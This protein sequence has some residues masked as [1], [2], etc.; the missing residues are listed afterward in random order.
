MDLKRRFAEL[1]IWLRSSQVCGQGYGS[2]AL[3]ALTRFLH[4]AFGITEFIL[5][6]SLRNTRAIRAYAKAGFLLLPLT[7]EEQAERYGPGDYADTVVMVKRLLD[8]T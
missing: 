8:A 3:Q 2:D 4:G 7:D 5:R 6:P 1:D